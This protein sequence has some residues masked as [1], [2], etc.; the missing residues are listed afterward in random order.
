[1][2][3]QLIMLIVPINN[4]YLVIDYSQSFKLDAAPVGK[5]ANIVNNTNSS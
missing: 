4:A 5:T 2:K 1:M 3:F